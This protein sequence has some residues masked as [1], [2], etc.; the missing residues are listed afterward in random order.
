MILN[1]RM[2]VGQHRPSQHST[3]WSTKTC[4]MWSQRAAED[5][6]RFSLHISDRTRKL[7]STHK[8]VPAKERFFIA[9]TMYGFSDIIGIHEPTNYLYDVV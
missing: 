8:L 6:F 4:P 9:T 3:Q 2:I 7:M 5:H 1:A